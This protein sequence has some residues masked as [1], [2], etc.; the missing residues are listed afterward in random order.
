MVNKIGYEKENWQT[1]I[2]LLKKA[3]LAEG[4]FFYE[5][6]TN[7]VISSGIVQMQGILMKEQLKKIPEAEQ[8]SFFENHYRFQK[9]LKASLEYNAIEKAWPDSLYLLA[10]KKLITISDISFIDK[11]G[12]AHIP[13]LLGQLKDGKETQKVLWLEI[14]DAKY[15]LEGSLNGDIKIIPSQSK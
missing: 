13:M 14:P 5:S 2:N 12:F 3:E 4:Y 15:I 10:E 1:I 11:E 7:A 6:I 9:V 8:S